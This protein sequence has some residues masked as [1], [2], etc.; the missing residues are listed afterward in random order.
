MKASDFGDR[1]LSSGFRRTAHGK[2]SRLIH[3]YYIWEPDRIDIIRYAYEN[4]P[5]HCPV[6]QHLA[7]DYRYD[8]CFWEKERG[9]EGMTDR[10]KPAYE[11]F[12]VSAQLALPHE[13]L[14]RVNK[15][16]QQYG[17][18]LERHLSADDT[19]HERHCYLEHATAQEKQ[20]CKKMHV[21]YDEHMGYGFYE[22][23][24]GDS[25]DCDEGE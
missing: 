20:G 4:I 10:V 2:L 5:L 15:G 21:R 6:L 23:K 7:D 22:R 14:V 1:F 24:E 9:L 13:F 16:I 3:T 18:E 25:E 8:L 17:L 11:P 12:G 19:W